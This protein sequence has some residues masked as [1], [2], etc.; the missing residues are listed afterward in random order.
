M[1]I[2]SRIKGSTKKQGNIRRKGKAS[3][4]YT[5]V[6]LEPRKLM[7]SMVVNADATDSGIVESECQVEVSQVIQAT[8]QDN[9]VIGRSFFVDPVNGNDSNPGTADQPFASYLPFVWAYDQ[10]DPNIGR[11]TLQWGDHVVFRT[12]VHDATFQ[13]PS[14]VNTGTHRGLYLRGLSGTTEAPIVF[15]AE[16]G[17]IINPNP[18]NNSEWFSAEI[19]QSEHIEFS[20][21]EFT[22]L[23]TGLHVATSSGIEISDN[24]FY[25]IDGDEDDNLS[26]IHI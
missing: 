7:A 23:G 18:A 9:Q 13:N 19:I 26:L 10:A 22:G 24:Y 20:G 17:A 4:P 14:D 11:V 1:G 16:P 25:D 15:R 5:Y 3:N 6:D 8:S 21:F 12:G 2:Q